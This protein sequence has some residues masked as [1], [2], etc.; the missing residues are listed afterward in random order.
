MKTIEELIERL[1]TRHPHFRSWAG[2]LVHYM[3]GLVFTFAVA[4]VTRSELHGNASALQEE[5][6]L[7]LLEYNLRTGRSEF[8]PGIEQVTAQV[9]LYL[10]MVF[11]IPWQRILGGP[12]R[13]SIRDDSPPRV[14]R[15]R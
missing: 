10:P 4:D 6:R 11:G 12:K 7:T 8:V 9:A 13:F 15:S 14:R 2:R 3:P 5:L 1:E